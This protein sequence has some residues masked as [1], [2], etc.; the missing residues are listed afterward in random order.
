MLPKKQQ[1]IYNCYL[2]NSRHGQP[3][4][5]RKDFSDISN[6]IKYLLV[7]LEN[8]FN[9]YSHIKIDEYFEA[10]HQLHP[11]E[12]YPFLNFFTTRAAIKT[13]SIYKKL[14]EDQNPENQFDEIKESV[15]F[16]GL[17]CLKN[18]IPLKSYLSHKNGYIHSWLL[19]YREHKI[20]PYSLMELGTINNSFSLLTEDERELYSNTMLEK[21]ETFKTRYHASTKTKN[22]VKLLTN[23]IEEFVK[24]EL[25]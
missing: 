24:K 7:K 5:P 18:K 21:F 3:F 4:Q 1:V 10:P 22:Y 2:K 6:E 23:K 15:H 25:Q 16:I 19:H 13:Y 20:N 12:K 8:F 17:F 9:K 11:D 14:K